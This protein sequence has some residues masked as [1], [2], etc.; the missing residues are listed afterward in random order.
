MEDKEYS[1]TYARIII[2]IEKKG[3]PIKWKVITGTGVIAGVFSSK[4][5][6]ARKEKLHLD[7]KSKQ[8]NF[9]LDEVN[10][11]IWIKPMPVDKYECF[12]S[13]RCSDCIILPIIDNELDNIFGVKKVFV[14][15]DIWNSANLLFWED[16]VDVYNLSR[17]VYDMLMENFMLQ[18]RIKIREICT[19][20]RGIWNDGT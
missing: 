1:N 6:L 11:E 9:I 17:D 18:D 4:E 8:K 12:L 5:L 13:V 20:P 10:N 15:E 2:P 7:N 19:Y 3:E 16:L 14:Y